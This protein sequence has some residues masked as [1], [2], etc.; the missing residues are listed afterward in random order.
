MCGCGHSDTCV[1]SGFDSSVPDPNTVGCPNQICTNEVCC[2]NFCNSAAC[3]VGQ[4]Q[5]ADAATTL[6]SSNPCDPSQCCE[7]ATYSCDDPDGDGVQSPY[8]C[9]TLNLVSDPSTVPCTTQNCDDQ[10]C[11]RSIEE[12][13]IYSCND[14]DGD[15]VQS[16]YDCESYSSRL[17]LRSNPQS[18]SCPAA[19]NCDPL[20][21]CKRKPIIWTFATG[22]STTSRVR[23]DPMIITA[24]TTSTR[25]LPNLST[26]ST[27]TSKDSTLQSTLT[28]SLEPKQ[29]ST[30]QSRSESDKYFPI[31]LGCNVCS[32]RIRP[33]TLLL[34][35]GQGDAKIESNIQ[36]GKASVSGESVTSSVAGPFTVECH[37]RK[38]PSRSFGSENMILGGI[39]VATMRET[40]TEIEC[41][42]SQKQQLKQTIRIH[43]SCSE[44]LWVDDRFGALTMHGY[45]NSIG[46]VHSLEECKKYEC[47]DGHLEEQDDVVSAPLCSVCAHGRPAN[48][49]LK[50]VAGGPGDVS[51]DQDGKT[52]VAGDT[53]RV[54][55]TEDFSLRCVDARRTK[56]VVSAIAENLI[57]GSRFTVALVNRPT[58]ITCELIWFSS[59]GEHVQVITVHTSCSKPLAIGDQF[60]AIAISAYHGFDGV[61][62]SE[63][64]PTACDPT[65]MVTS[66]GAKQVGKSAKNSRTIGFTGGRV[67]AGC[68]DKGKKRKAGPPAIEW[69]ARREKGRAEATRAHLSAKLELATAGAQMV[70][71]VMALALSALLVFAIVSRQRPIRSVQR[72]FGSRVVPKGPSSRQL[73]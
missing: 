2:R 55:A 21:C 24:T 28:V 22:T 27:H 1:S 49:E 16:P 35:L 36:S 33:T 41:T 25:V 17:I 47:N 9:G 51:N 56:S 39:F 67:G 62:V 29:T 6:C 5:I 65:I 42:I 72:H 69:K 31:A 63:T 20:L 13:N 64:D 18:I 26:T 32:H 12:F 57:L 59:A 44:L 7:D 52:V 4:I 45:S 60:G 23:T 70:L 19:N 3:P 15:G 11:C 38:H 50:L 14:P 68:M 8:D 73:A 66:K 61:V 34:R 10:T 48:L 43:T 30:P 54:G 58:E 40:P 37:D 46:A 53:V 71:L